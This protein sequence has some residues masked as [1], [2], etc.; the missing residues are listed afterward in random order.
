MRR[1][2]AGLHWIAGRFCDPATMERVIEPVIADLQCEHADAVQRRQVWR[3]AWIRVG[4]CAA[5]WKTVGLHASLSI[6]WALSRGTN[7]PHPR[8]RGSTLCGRRCRTL[9]SNRGGRHIRQSLLPDVSR[10]L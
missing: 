5:F 1:P 4:G 3:T 10:I 2:G 6:N 8:T 9:S 7:S